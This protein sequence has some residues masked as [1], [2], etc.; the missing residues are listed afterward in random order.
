MCTLTAIPGRLL[1]EGDAG[2]ANVRVVFSR[3]E[4]RLRRPA[5]PP[6]ETTIGGRRVLMPL[7]GAAGG[8]WIAASD[9][10][11]VF[12]LLNVTD[13]VSAGP[14]STAPAWPGR[15]SRGAIIP[16][17][18]GAADLD[19]ATAAARAIDA[20][21]HA[22]FA[23]LCVSTAERL[24]LRSDG[25]R[26]TLARQPMSHPWMRTSSSLGD[27]R[28]AGP[29]RRLFDAWC[30]HPPID[31]A[32]QDRF[33]RHCWAERRELSVL[34]ERPDARTVSITTVECGPGEVRMAYDEVPI[35]RAGGRVAGA[36]APAFRCPRG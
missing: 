19:E 1:A 12:A 7:D 9:A 31:A 3:D 6:I 15:V 23:L 34:M 25:Q 17:M 11:L 28:V 29:R 36:S 27:A 2:P 30:R 10:G 32:S 33:H 14:V 24:E 5:R 26:L 21:D 16:A 35:V 4:R 18:A 20:A 13:H 8:T 22:P